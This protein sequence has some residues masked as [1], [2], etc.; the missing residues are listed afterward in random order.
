MISRM[1]EQFGR[2]V[3]TVKANGLW[4]RTYS[5]FFTDHGEYLGDFALVEKWPSGVSNALT[6]EPLIVGRC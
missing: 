3:N 5:F 4:D 6:H 1:D 2:V